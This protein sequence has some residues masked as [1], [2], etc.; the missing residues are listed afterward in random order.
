MEIE[1]DL[2]AWKYLQYDGETGKKRTVNG[3]SGEASSF[4]ELEDV[5]FSDLQNGQVPKYNSDTQK[6]ENGDESGGTVTD[7]Q[8]NGESVVNQ[9][10][11]AQITSYKEVTQAEYNALPASKLTDN[12]MYCI[13]DY[14]P[15]ND[16][17]PTAVYSTEERE[18]GVWIDGKPVY[19]K[20]V[21]LNKTIQGNTWV[22]LPELNSLNIDKCIDWKFYSDAN[23]IVGGQYDWN[24]TP[25]EIWLYRNTSLSMKAIHIRYTKT[26]DTAGSGKWATNG[27]LAHHYSQTEHVVG[28]WIDGKPLYE[29]TVMGHFSSSSNQTTISHGVS[30]IKYV[31]KYEAF[32]IFQNQPRFI[33][34]MYYDASGNVQHQFGAFIYDIDNSGIFITYGN[35]LKSWSQYDIYVTI[36]YTKTTD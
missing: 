12:I 27:M 7:V 35:T 34:Q 28:T 10:G 15:E 33:P 14:V 8:V 6:W 20:V 3:G 16:A 23:T 36:Q 30:N 9:Q 32:Y 13:K 18:V 21:T 31:T 22:Q 17:F 4:S 11:E 29:K 5:N 24:A 19:E 25:N 1:G 26:T 2:M